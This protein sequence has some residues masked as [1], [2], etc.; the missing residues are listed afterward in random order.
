MKKNFKLFLTLLGITIMS[1]SLYAQEDCNNNSIQQLKVFN[2]KEMDAKWK[3]FS[4]D[5]GFKNL[6]SEV[7]KKGFSK[8]D[9]EGTYW[10]FTG[11]TQQENKI[12]D[13]VF[14]AYD[15]ISKDKTQSCS[16][17]WRKIGNDIYKAYIIFPSAQKD[18]FTAVENS[19]EWFAGSNNEIQVAHS[20]KTCFRKCT[21]K[22]C[23]GWCLAAV[24]VCAAVPAAIAVATGGIGLGPAIGIF[25]ACAGISC[26]TC[27]AI[28]MIGC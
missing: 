18:F 17:I 4:A 5:A 26:A 21:L 22:S 23:P 15:F 14:C 27:M 11:K 28:C 7:T 9:I 10:G 16:M 25:A 20:W 12:V 24:P 2:S 13:A 19:Q 6:F 3:E 8:M 1:T